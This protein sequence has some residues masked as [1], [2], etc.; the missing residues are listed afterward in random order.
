MSGKVTLPR[1]HGGYLTAVGA[2]MAGALVGPAFLP[3]L[4][5]GVALTAAFLARGPADRLGLRM[6]LGRWDPWLLA[7]LGSIIIS[8][9][10]SVALTNGPV[11]GLVTTAAALGVIAASI[12]ARRARS[13]RAMTFELGGMACLGGSAGLGAWASGASSTT[14]ATLAV[15]LGTHAALSVPLVRTELRRRERSR[16]L[17]ADLATLVSLAVAAGIALTL[18]HPEGAAGLLPRTLQVVLRRLGWMPAA[19][20]TWVGLRETALLALAI[21]ALVVWL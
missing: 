10:V 4:G 1:E 5:T 20:P 2:G 17:G 8:G 9:A 11:A 18:G 3:A 15:V 16:S 7:L 21:T 13:H 6:P 12:S 14:A 19:G